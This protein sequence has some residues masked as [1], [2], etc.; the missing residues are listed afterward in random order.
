VFTREGM[1]VTGFNVGLRIP[2]RTDYL[3]PEFF[4]GNACLVPFAANG[5]DAVGPYAIDVGSPTSAAMLNESFSSMNPH[6]GNDAPPSI[7]FDTSYNSV[8]GWQFIQK[9]GASGEA[10][11][12]PMLRWQS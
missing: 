4:N 8:A 3:T 5:G 12:T 6:T 11:I 2:Q 7:S 10:S 1:T 9:P